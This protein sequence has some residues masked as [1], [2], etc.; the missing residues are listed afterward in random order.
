MPFL[1]RT[2][3]TATCDDGSKCTTGDA[4][5]NGNCTGKLKNCDD[6]NECTDDSCDPKSGCGEVNAAEGVGCGPFDCITMHVCRTGVCTAETTPEGA[7]CANSTRSVPC[8]VDD[9]GPC[10]CS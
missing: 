6:G 9:S 7:T 2:P 10:S 8:T 4:C 3:A 5:A 1:Q